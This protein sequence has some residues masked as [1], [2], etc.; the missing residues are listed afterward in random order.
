MITYDNYYGITKQSD[1]E[2]YDIIVRDVLFPMLSSVV[3]DDKVDLA[4]ADLAVYA[5]RF[6]TDAGMS[7]EQI[8]RLKERLQ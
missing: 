4:S 2:K 1:P 3:G 7:S 6:L 8:D 5:E